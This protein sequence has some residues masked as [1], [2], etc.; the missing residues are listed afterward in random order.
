MDVVKATPLAPLRR[1]TRLATSLEIIGPDTVAE[2][3]T[4]QFRAVAHYS[5][6]LVGDT[7]I[8]GDVDIA[9]LGKLSANYG[10]TSGCGWPEGDFDGDGDVDLVDLGAMAGN[11]GR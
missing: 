1:T 2:G 8:D 11:Y 9:D 7:D 3:G 6:V 4:A 10:K 5:E